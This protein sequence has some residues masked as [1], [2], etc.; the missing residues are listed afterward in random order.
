[1]NVSVQKLLFIFFIFL[2]AGLLASCNFAPYQG[3]AQVVLDLSWLFPSEGGTDVGARAGT[4]PGY[5]VP[6]NIVGQVTS[7]EVT[8]SGAGINTETRTYIKWPRL[9]SVTVP[10]GKQRTVGVRININPAST[11]AVLAFGGEA[12]LR[13]VSAG[14]QTKVLIPLSPVETKIVVP[15]AINQTVA[16]FNSLPFNPDTFKY[17]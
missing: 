16:Q 13:Y 6:D 15:D 7:I 3:E 12:T 8:I 2:L 5:N 1:M 9:L 14:Q 17:G 4:V 10:P 11:S